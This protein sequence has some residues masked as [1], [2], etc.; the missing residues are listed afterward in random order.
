MVYSRL[1]ENGAHGHPDI[2]SGEH[3]AL[4]RAWEALVALRELDL[5]ADGLD[6][7][8]AAV[9]EQA[10]VV[11][12]ALLEHVKGAE[13]PNGAL[14]RLARGHNGQAQMAQAQQQEHRQLA[15]AADRLLRAT[16]GLKGGVAS[17]LEI[18]E[19]AI[20]LEIAVARHRNRL[21]M[22]QESSMA[23]AV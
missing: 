3:G 19:D 17:A 20:Q 15:L 22:L 18:T 12:G 5:R 8:A 16:V 11:A 1:R 6:A 14:K 23:G 2:Q 4:D 10:K 21:L 7:W 13:A 9:S